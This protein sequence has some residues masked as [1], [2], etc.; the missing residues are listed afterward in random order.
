[1]R[2]GMEEQK[3]QQERVLEMLKQSPG[4]GTTGMF[5]SARGLEIGLSIDI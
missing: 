4:G 5:C 2:Y 1:V 3:S